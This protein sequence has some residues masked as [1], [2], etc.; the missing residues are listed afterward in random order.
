MNMKRIFIAL[1]AVALLFVGC[2]KEKEPYQN[3]YR[4]IV[5]YLP[6]TITINGISGAVTPDGD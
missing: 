2:E 6:Q 4:I 5:D 3:P 1:T